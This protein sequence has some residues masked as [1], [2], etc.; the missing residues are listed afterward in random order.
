MFSLIRN[1]WKTIKYLLY[2]F[3]L[4]P[5]N[6]TFPF[7]DF[8]K[9]KYDIGKEGQ[10]AL[11]T[12]SRPSLFVEK[13]DEGRKSD[14][15]SWAGRLSFSLCTNILSLAGTLDNKWF[16]DCQLVY[17]FTIITSFVA[18]TF[19]SC[20]GNVHIIPLFSLNKTK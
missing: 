6:I 17:Y 11:S 9:E 8:D 3:H 2:R 18:W 19:Y 13:L 1:R 4:G 16:Y 12:V 15:G 5:N 14:K 7:A 20:G 10:N